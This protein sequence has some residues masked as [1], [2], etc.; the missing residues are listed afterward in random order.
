MKDTENLE[1]CLLALF[2]QDTHWAKE[3]FAWHE[4]HDF[5]HLPHALWVLRELEAHSVLWAEKKYALLTDTEFL[6]TSPIR[7]AGK[8]VLP[9]DWHNKADLEQLWLQPTEGHLPKL[10]RN[11][12]NPEDKVKLLDFQQSPSFK[13][14]GLDKNTEE[15][16]QARLEKLS[17]A[18]ENKRVVI[19]LG[20]QTN[21]YKK[22]HKALNVHY[23][24]K[25]QFV[26]DHSWSSLGFT[27]PGMKTSDN[28]LSVIQA[29]ETV[30][31]LP[32]LFP[33][34][35]IA[36]KSKIMFSL[37]GYDMRHA[38]A[39]MYSDCN[40][41]ARSHT[42]PHIP[43]LTHFEFAYTGL[44]DLELANVVRHKDWFA[45]TS[46]CR[47]STAGELEELTQE[48]VAGEYGIVCLDS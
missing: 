46:F 4:K 39:A 25:V 2:R 47:T 42:K 23:T 3:V 13:Y 10:W 36:Q 33:D 43:P 40:K 19:F 11:S 29:C 41:I 32:V 18:I 7:R 28:R 8:E 34:E 30:R 5:E 26:S 20:R 44:T 17:K 45:L 16:L 14:R 22:L 24:G 12:D 15:R 35:P 48:Q 9:K 31:R 38:L 27:E 37:D 1:A 21:I 6:L